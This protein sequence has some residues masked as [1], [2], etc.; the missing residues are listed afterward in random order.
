MHKLMV[1][2]LL[3]IICF[4]IWCSHEM[5]D[6]DDTLMYTKGCN[7]LLFKFLT[8][9][10]LQRSSKGVHNRKEIKFESAATPSRVPEPVCI[11]MDAQDASGLRL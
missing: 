10:V 11:K 4:Q 1:Y 5:I 2:V 6:R 3:L 9:W 7:F 8:K